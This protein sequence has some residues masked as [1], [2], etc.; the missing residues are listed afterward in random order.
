M[1]DQ[2]SLSKLKAENARLIS[3]LEP[4]QIEWRRPPASLPAALEP[5][6]LSTGERVALFRGLFHGRTDV[7]PTRWESNAT[8]NSG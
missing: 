7:C 4:H 6:R 1:P 2:D 5:S 8:G 3:L